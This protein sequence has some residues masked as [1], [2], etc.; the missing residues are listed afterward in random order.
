MNKVWIDNKTK[1]LVV[2]DENCIS[3]CNDCRYNNMCTREA[4]IIFKAVNKIR[5]SKE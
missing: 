2:A 1:K 5:V 3:N 4:A